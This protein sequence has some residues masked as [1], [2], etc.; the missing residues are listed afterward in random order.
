MPVITGKQ[1]HAN[2]EAYLFRI[3]KNK[4]IDQIRKQKAARQTKL[5]AQVELFPDILV[6]DVEAAFQVLLKHV[7]PLQRTVFLLRDV[8]GFS[9]A[10]VAKML[11]TTEGAVKASL[12]R[13]RLTISVLKHQMTEEHAEE[14]D[15]GCDKEL[16]RA[17]VTAF[18]SGDTQMLVQLVQNDVIHPVAAASRILNHVIKDKRGTA[19]NSATLSMAA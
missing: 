18:R 5:E 3:A 4:W 10:E 12:H 16:L 2:P 7:S 19:G 17:Y 9:G 1:E 6:V 13:A 11:E 14:K 15:E 8:F